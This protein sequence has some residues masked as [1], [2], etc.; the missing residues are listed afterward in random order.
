[1]A[2]SKT[3][4]SFLDGLL[5]LS[6]F[7]RHFL[8][9]YELLT[10]KAEKVVQIVEKRV[11]PSVDPFQYMAFGLTIYAIT[12]F[13]TPEEGML[14]AEATFFYGLATWFITVLYLYL[15]LGITF[16]LF[17][18]KASIKRSFD[19]FLI[20]TALT[21][22]T[23][24]TLAGG[25]L[26]FIAFFPEGPVRLVLLL[27][28]MYPMLFTMRVYRQFWSMGYSTV[29]RNLFLAFLLYLGAIF[30]IA[31]VFIGLFQGM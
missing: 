31:A 5:N 23:T 3:Q 27:V 17:N 12:Q 1:M 8:F 11:A 2:L 26:L 15:Y 10:S 14:G 18:K 21:S 16:W 28:A 20:L 13:V 24:F 22:G 25:A 4:K 9:L 19:E 30:G 7:K 6:T 29:L